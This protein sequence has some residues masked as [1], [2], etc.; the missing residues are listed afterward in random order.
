MIN[1]DQIKE[2]QSRIEDL[3]KFLQIEE[4]K[5]EIAND[6]ENKTLIPPFRTLDGLGDI[7]ARKIVS[8]R[9]KSPFI[10]IEDLQGR[11]KVSQTIIDQ[12]RLM[13]ILDGLPESSQLSL[14]DL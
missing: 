8:E 3:Y 6:E 5:I 11:G 2:A 9:Q 13:G 1:S 14:F 10:S 7:V 4:K 12:M